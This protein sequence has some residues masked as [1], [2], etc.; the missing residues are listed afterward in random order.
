M[1]VVGIGGLAVGA[2]FGARSVFQSIDVEALQRAQRA[3]TQAMYNHFWRIATLT[4]PL[5]SGDNAIVEARRTGTAINET[6]AARTQLVAFSREHTL[7]VPIFELPWKPVATP[8]IERRRPLWRRLFLL[9]DPM[10]LQFQ[11]SSSEPP[12]DAEPNTK[13]AP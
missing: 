4:F 12:Q 10:R 11:L 9:S 1:D 2:F 8:V 6:I 5:G 13:D 3:S 7:F